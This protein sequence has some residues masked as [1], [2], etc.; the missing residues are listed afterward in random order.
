MGRYR[1]TFTVAANYEPLK[2]A[3][4]D[5]RELVNTKADLINPVTWQQINGDVWI[6]EGMAV[7]VK[8]EH[9][10]YILKNPI[11]YFEESS[12][13][14][15]ANYTDIEEINKKIG[16]LPEGKT[17]MDVINDIE[18]SGGAYDDTEIV[19]R[20][21]VV[22]EK[23]KV[24]DADFEALKSLIGET[25]VKTQIDEAIEALPA[26]AKTGNVNDLIQDPDD[27]LTL[28]CGDSDED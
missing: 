16:V 2:A 18:V 14:K 11:S 20:I 9:A 27:Y 22:E 19:E 10:I 6:Y 13:V 12:W 28:S 23:Q 8:E 1:G 3:P 21:S 15:V 25:S 26:V 4:F 7:R 5:A 24:I 17:L